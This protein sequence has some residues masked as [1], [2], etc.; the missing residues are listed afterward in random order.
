MSEGEQYFW[1]NT[2]KKKT[3]L[4]GSIF[5][6]VI[7]MSVYNYVLKYESLTLSA[8]GEILILKVNKYY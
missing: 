1:T 2:K 7:H 6:N 4:K 8:F 3:S 5:G